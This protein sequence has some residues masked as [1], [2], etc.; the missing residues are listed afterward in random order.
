[1][2]EALTRVSPTAPTS[3]LPGPVIFGPMGAA[4]RKPG[5]LSAD[6]LR[7]TGY[8]GPNHVKHVICY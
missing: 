3:L 5:A 4:R 7:Q 6:D 2:G 1:M 8:L